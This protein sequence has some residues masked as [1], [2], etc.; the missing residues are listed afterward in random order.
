MDISII[1]AT[2]G[3]PKL[4]AQTLESLAQANT[5]GI[6]WEMV[7]VDNGD[8]PQTRTVAEKFASR[9]TLHLLVENQQGKNRALNQAL[10]QASGKLL[11]FT[12]DDVRVEPDWLVKTWTG[13]SRWPDHSVFGGCIRV[14]LPSEDLPLDVGDRYYRAAY[15]DADWDDEEGPYKAAKVF[16]PNMAIRAAVFRDGASFHPDLGPKGSNYIMGGETELVQRLE[17]AGMQAVYLPESVVWHQIRPDQM[18]H[19]WLSQRAFC[20]GR[21][22]AYCG[23]GPRPVFLLGHPLGLVWRRFFATLSRWLC[24]NRKN[25]LLLD[26]DIAHFKGMMYQYRETR[27]E[28]PR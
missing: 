2:R 13:A 22:L 6:S 19:D 7:L 8:D 25:R 21:M 27:N 16:G 20:F 23:T 3:R 5:T 14:D 9:F 28:T 17:R 15:A 24:V 11:L 12:D 10:R 4:L 18:T 1:I 26:M